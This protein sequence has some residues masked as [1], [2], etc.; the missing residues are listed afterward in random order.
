MAFTK[1]VAKRVAVA[2]VVIFGATVLNFFLF[3]LAPGDAANLSHIPNASP[4]LLR[5]LRHQFGLD[6]STLTQLRLYLVELLHGNLGVSFSNRQ[7][8]AHNLMTA[9]GNTA[10]MAIPGIV[11]AVA[12]AVVTGII[13]AWRRGSAVDHVS[14]GTALTLY[15]LPS[16]WL[17]IMLI[18]V[19]RG[20]LPSG[21]KSDPFLAGAGW[22]THTTDVLNH[23]ILPC[24]TYAL[25]LY[26]Q[27]MVVVR[28]SMLETL[29]E[30]YI[31]TAK[32]KGLSNRVILRRHALRN[33]LLPVV[34]LVGLAI[35]SMVGGVILIEA[36]FSWPGIGEAVYS[37][38]STRDYP[39]LQGAFLLLTVAVVLAN[40]VVDLIYARLD[41]R[42][43]L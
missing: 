23:L 17:A 11:L 29:S 18:F 24:L 28:S 7:P 25:V 16:Q 6:A 2:I 38:V 31:L 14:R 22:W 36:A 8:V 15:A 32:A 37:A 3:R 40:L 33:A 5:T 4:E 34:T 13:A 39:T 10:L 12:M 35:G 41:P 42:V 21:G 1:Y 30:D 27:F 26:G 9:L 19:F 20:V 43:G